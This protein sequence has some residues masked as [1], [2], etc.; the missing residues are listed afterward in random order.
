MKRDAPTAGACSRRASIRLPAMRRP[1]LPKLPKPKLRRGGASP[2]TPQSTAA[3]QFAAAPWTPP[4]AGR[5]LPAL[6]LILAAA[7]AILVVVLLLTT[8]GTDDQQEVRQTVERFAQASRDKDYQALC[9]DLLSAALVQQLRTVD[10]PCEVVVRIG[11]GDVQNP[12]LEVR[13][14]KVDG[15]KAT[16]QVRGAAARQQP[17]DTKILLVREHGE[18]RISS[19]PGGQKP[20]VTP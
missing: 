16:A 10:R 1:S 12:T 18:W 20:A 13:S 19:P 9:D 7:V 6:K 15:D 17:L 3:P 2:G 8:C 11:L 4:T 14:V 5:R